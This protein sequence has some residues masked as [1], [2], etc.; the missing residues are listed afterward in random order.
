FT[1]ANNKLQAWPIKQGTKAPQAAGQIHTDME[2][3]FIRAQVVEAS[4]LLA[5]GSVQSLHR[6]GRVRTEGRDYE[7]REGD[8]VEILFS[9]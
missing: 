6:H 4:E 9:P 7:I 5:E 3:G 1:T 8:V 2:K